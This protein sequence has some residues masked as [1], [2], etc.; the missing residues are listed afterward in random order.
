MSVLRRDQCSCIRL[1]WIHLTVH[2]DLQ[3][4]SRNSELSGEVTLQ[5][6]N[7]ET[8][9]EGHGHH[10]TLRYQHHL[11]CR[12]TDTLRQTLGLCLE[13]VSYAAGF[14]CNSEFL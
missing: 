14:Y 11:H 8:D 5:L 13:S 10:M 2:R 12:R 7:A 1:G 6:L 3:H 4:I 9:G